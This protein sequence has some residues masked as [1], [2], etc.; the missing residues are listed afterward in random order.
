MFSLSKDNTVEDVIS[1][2]ADN[3]LPSISPGQANKLDNDTPIKERKPLPDHVKYVFLGDGNTLPV[4]ISSKLTK[5]Q[6]EELV[7]VLQSH[8]KALGWTISD[9]KGI[10][11]SICTHRILLETGAEP[12]HQP[13]RRLNPVVLEVVKAESRLR[14]FPGKLRTRWKGPFEVTKVCTHGAVEIRSPSSLKSFIVNGHRL[15]PYHEN[16]QP[17]HEEREGLEDPIYSE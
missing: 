17:E 14:L 7:A 9:I 1:N 12:V 5:T 3:S 16:F 15:K 6:E 2:L 13:Q 4:I 11:P 10:S 8:K